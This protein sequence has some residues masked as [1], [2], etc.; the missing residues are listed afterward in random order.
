ML[1]TSTLMDGDS[2]SGV[3][4]H[5]LHLDTYYLKKQGIYFKKRTIIHSYSKQKGIKNERR[6]FY[7]I[8]FG[9]SVSLAQ[10]SM[11]GKTVERTFIIHR[12]HCSQYA[13]E[14]DSEIWLTSEASGQYLI[15]FGGR[16]KEQS[17][18]LNFTEYSFHSVVS[19]IS[20]GFDKDSKGEV[21]VPSS[22]SFRLAV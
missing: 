8:W 13:N 10:A 7:L 17:A 6:I 11:H 9:N 21:P 19:R 5:I 3:E 16:R 2:Y 14:T 22:S 1:E 15:S 4:I 12:T 20:T 18:T